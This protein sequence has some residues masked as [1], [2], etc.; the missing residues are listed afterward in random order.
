VR[1]SE[2]PDSQ[3]V[4]FI[5]GGR[6]ADFVRERGG[7]TSPGPIVDEEGRR[8]GSHDGLHGFTVGQ[9]RGV[10]VASPHPLYVLRLEPERDELVVG[11]AERLDASRVVA[12]DWNWLRKPEP[13]EGTAAKVR[14]RSPA[15]PVAWIG[16]EGGQVSLQL[17]TPV[18]AVAPG[19][20]VVLYGGPGLDEVL[21][22]GTIQSAPSEAHCAPRPLARTPPTA[23]AMLIMDPTVSG[24][25]TCA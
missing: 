19:Q 14:Y 17:A 7:A 16:G 21:G 3:D 24:A 18:R 9:R 11:P 25:S 8:L 5:P 12:G 1:T 20:A 23:P 15:A 2:K 4:C 22:G 6:T 10:G 13:N